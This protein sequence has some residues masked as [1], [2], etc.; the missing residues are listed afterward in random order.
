MDIKPIETVYNG[1]RFRSR[2][3]AR[4]AVFFDEAGIKYEYEPEGFVLD[5]GILYL[6]DFYLPW[7][8]AYV[9]IKPVGYNGRKEAMQKLEHLFC[10]NEVVCLYCEGDPFECNMMIYCND[11]TE[12]SG[13]CSWWEAEFCEGAMF[14]VD[15]KS[16][17]VDYGYSK[18][19]ICILVST[20]EKQKDRTFLDSS[21]HECCLE[22]RCKM[23]GYRS[24]LKEYK[25]K[26]RQ[27]RFEYGENQSTSKR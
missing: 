1:Y 13:G 9:E 23:V 11:L 6:P 10:K 3:E 20:S 2:L 19:G 12:S 17:N 18:H 7:F 26:A 15:P 22:Q 16:E 5:N 27:A 14:S 4:W 25:T 21:Y 24:M 8:H